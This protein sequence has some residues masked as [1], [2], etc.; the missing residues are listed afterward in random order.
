DA[1]EPKKARKFK[2]HAS[3]KL[4]TIPISPKEP[5]K[6]PVKKPEVA[7]KVVPAM[8]SSR[9]SQ[10]EVIIKDTPSV[11]MSIKRSPTKGKRSKEVPDEQQCKISGIDEGNSTK[12]GVPGVPKY[13]F[14]SEKESWGDS[15][16]EDDDEDN[17]GDESND[18]KDNDDDNDDNNDDDDDDKNDDDDEADSDRTESDRIKI[19]DL[20][21]SSTEYDEEEE[22]QESERVYTPREFVPTN[23]E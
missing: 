17:S 23:E 4:K 8:K 3:P 15:R 22:E 14:E 9:K 1:K 12:P 13:D 10:A 18:D 21:P 6:K 16:E 7:K 5:T 2:K 20:N 19:H 11:S